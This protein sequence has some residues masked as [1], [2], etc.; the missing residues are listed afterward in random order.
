MLKQSSSPPLH[1]SST[2]APMVRKLQLWKRLTEEEQ[3]AVMGLPFDVAT[4]QPGEYV[5]REGTKASSSCLLIDGF[6][7]RVKLSHEGDR[8]I[9]A[10]QMRGDVVDLQNSLLGCA[11]HSVQAMT[12]A[13]VAKIPREAVIDLAF[14]FPNV[15]LAMWYD[16]LVDASVFREWILNIARRDAQARIAH[17]LCEFGIR[18]E[19]LGLGERNS[20]ELPMT[21]EQ[22]ADATGLTSV[23][24]NR[25][26]QELEARALITR[27]VRYVAVADWPT[28]CEAGQFDDAYLHLKHPQDTPNL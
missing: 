12:T 24:V 21:Q 20:F 28:L 23:H 19:A 11:D 15:G 7:C 5:V 3:A 18:L 27:T 13:K 26:L 4:L 17:L 6:A 14:S 1:P 22:I 8:S 16:T 9:S 25:S 10:V 2:L